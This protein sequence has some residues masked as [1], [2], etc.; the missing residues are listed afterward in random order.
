[1]ICKQCG[2][3]SESKHAKKKFCSQTC[4][5]T[6]NDCKSVSTSLTIKDADFLQRWS[7]KENLPV[8]K[9]IYKALMEYFERHKV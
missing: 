7:A 3:E 4:M 2:K 9:L 1:M 5:Y 8:S 6:Y